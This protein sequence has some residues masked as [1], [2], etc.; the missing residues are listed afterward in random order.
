MDSQD[1]VL[2]S[3]VPMLKP[4]EFEMWKIRIKQYMLLTD[5]AL[6]EVVEHGP[7][8][9]EPAVAGAPQKSDADKKRKQTEMKALS[10]LLL[11]IPNE[12]QHQFCTCPDAKSLWNA[13]EKRFYGTKSSKRNQKALL[14]QQYENFTSTKNESMTQ[15]FDRFNKL[16]GELVNVD[17]KMEKDEVNRK[18]L[19]SLSEEWT[20]YTVSFRQGDD[21]E[22]KELEDLYNDLRIF[23][24]EVEAKRRPTGYSHTI[25]LYSSE[26]PSSNINTASTANINPANNNHDNTNDKPS[27]SQDANGDA[28][29]EAFLANHVRSPLINDDLEQINADDLE[30]MDIKWQMA[31]LTMRMKRFIRRTG[32]NN[33]DAKRGDLAGFDK[34]KVRCYK[35]NEPGHYARECKESGTHQQ[36]NNGGQAYAPRPNR[37]NNSNSSQALVSQEGMGFDWSD[38]AEEAI[39]NHA[40]MAKITEPE[41][42]AEVSSKLCSDSCV[43]TVKKYRDHNQTMSDTI[44]TME[45]DRREYRIV[46]ENLEDQIKSYKENE[47]QFEYD[48]NYWKWEKKEFEKKLVKSGE[49]LESVKKELEKAKEDLDK[50]SKSSKALEEIL[51]AQVHDELKRGIGYHNTPPPRN[52]TYI[53]PTTDILDRLNREE[54]KEGVCNID[55]SSSDDEEEQRDKT[56]NKS[57]ETVPEEN[58]ILTNEKGGMPFVPSKNTTTS[59]KGKEKIVDQEP[60]TSQPAKG[61]KHTHRNDSDPGTSKQPQTSA[62]PRGNKRNWNNQWA[63][64]HGVDLNKINKP[65]PCFICCN[66]NHLAKDCYYNPFNQRMTFQNQRVNFQNQKQFQTRRTEYNSRWS[67]PKPVVK[68]QT[69]QK[70]KNQPKKKFN[71]QKKKVEKKTV[72]IVTKW[73]PKASLSNT[74]AST[75]SGNKSVA[76]ESSGNNQKDIEVNTA[77]SNSSSG[78]SNTGATTSFSLR[79]PIVTKYSSHEIPNKDY[80]LKLNRLTEG[81]P[82][83]IENLW[84]VDSGCSRH[85]TGNRSFLEDF[86]RFNG[87]YVAFGDNPKGGKVSGKGKVT[88]V[89]ESLILLKTPRKDNVYCLDLHGMPSEVVNCLFSKASVTESPLWH[90]RMG[91]MNIKTMNLLVKNQLVRG[92]PSKEF[93]LD[94][95]CVDCLKGKQHKASHKSKT[96][97]TIS[98]PLQLLH[99]DLFGPTN[100]M[101]IGKKSY[102]LVIIDDYS[103]FTWVFF[104]RTKDETSGLI[105]PFVKRVEN[106]VNL[107]VKV[108]RSDNGTEFKNA[109]LNSFCEEKGIERQFSA[110]RTPQQNGVAERRNRTLIEAARTMLADSKLPI[111]FWAE[112]VNTACYVQNRV[113]V[114]NKADDG[115]FVGYS[116]QT[117]AV[118]VFNT[119]SR[120]IEESD[121]VKFNEHTPNVHGTGPDW[122]FD[123][124]SLTNSLN[125][126]N[127]VDTGPIIKEKETDTPFVLFPPSTISSEEKESETEAQ[128][129]ASE[130]QEGDKE[131]AETPQL[132]SNVENESVDTSEITQPDPTESD[133]DDSNLGEILSEEP[134]HL[135]ITQ[136]NHP[137]SQVI[138]DVASPMIT[139]KQSRE[140][141]YVNT[142]SGMLSCFLSQNEPKKVLDAMKDP[143][144]IEA[145]QEELL[146]FVL[147]H[148]WDLVDLPKGHRVIGTKWIFRNKTD[149]RGIVIKNKARLVAQGYTQEEG[150]DYDDVFA[151]VARIEA[152]RLFLAFASYKGFKVYQMDVKSAFLYGTIDEEVYVCQPPGF[153]DPKYP[154]RVCK[155]R[156]ALYGL[157]Q[158]PRAWYDTLSSYLLENKFERGVIDKTLFIKRTK[159]DML[160]VQIYVD[161]IIFGSTKEDMCKEFEELMHKKFK[162]SSMGE[163]TL[164]LGLQVK[165]KRDGIFINQSKYV[166][167][168]HQKFGMNDAKP[169]STPM[170]THKHLTADVEGEEVDVHQY[171]SMI[172]SL[173]YLTAS[174]PDIMFVVCV[175]ARFQVRP[176]ESHLHAVKRIFKYLKGQPRLGLWYPND[177]SFDLVAYTDKD[178]GG[179]N[180]DRKSTSGGCQFLGGRLVSWQC[181]KQT[182]VSQS[183]TEAEYIAASQCCSQVLW[184]QNQMQDYGLSFLQTPIYIDNN[185]AIS[186]VN[187]PVKH[188][189]TKHIEIKYHLIR[190]CNEKKLIQVLKVHTNDQYANLF[191]KAFDVGRVYRIESIMESMCFI[192]DHNKVGYF[193]KDVHS[194]GFEDILDFLASSHIA[195]AA[196]INPTIYIQHQ[197][198]FWL[199]AVIQEEQ[200]V[201]AIQTTIC[202]HSLTLTPEKIRLHLQFHD[203]KGIS[204]LS[205]KTLMENLLKIGYTGSKTSLKYLKGKLC[206]QW[207]FFVHTLLHC[208]SKKTTGFG[209]FS[210]TM[211]SAL[212]CLATNQ[213]FNFSQMIFDDLVYNLENI[214]NSKVKT[215]YMFSRFVQEVIT[216]ELTAVPMNGDIYKSHALGHKVFANMKR[217][218]EGSNDQF[219]PLFSTMMRVNHPQGEA[220]GLQPTQPSISSDDLPTPITDTIPQFLEK[221][222]TPT[223]KKYQRKN[224][225][226]PS[227]SGSKPNEPLSQQ[228][229]HSPSDSTQR[230]TPGVQP[231]SSIKKVPSK[232]KDGHVVGEAQTTDVAQ[233]VHQAS[234]NISK[235][236][237]TTTPSEKS[238]GGPR[239]Q[240]TKGASSASARLKT[241]VKKLKDPVMEVNTSKPGESRFSQKELMENFSTIAKDLKAFE[242]NF[243]VHDEKHGSHEARL[244]ILEKLATAQH[245]MLKLHEAQLV[246]QAKVIQAQGAS[247]ASMK[248]TIRALRRRY[249]T[250]VAFTKGERR[251]EFKGES[252]QEKEVVNEPVQHS[253]LPVD[254]I[255]EVV[256]DSV[257]KGE[258][259]KEDEKVTEET[260]VAD[261]PVVDIAEPELQKAEPEINEDDLTI[262]ELLV[263][264]PE[265]VKPTKGVVFKEPEVVKK[266]D[267]PVDPKD[268]GKEKM[269]EEAESDSDTEVDEAKRKVLEYE[270]SEALARKLSM[271]DQERVNKEIEE[272]KAAA[273]KLQE[274]KEKKPVKKTQKKSISKTETEKRRIMVRYLSGALGKPVQ[275]FSRWNMEEI[276][277]KYNVTREAMH[278]EAMEEQQVETEE[279]ALVQRKRKRDQIEEQVT[280]EGNPEH[281]VEKTKETVADSEQQ[282]VQVIEKKEEIAEKTVEKE[283]EVTEQIEAQP[284][285]AIRKKSIAK[286]PKMSKEI[287][288]PSNISMW[289]YFENNQMDYFKV[290]RSDGTNEVFA[291]YLGIFRKLSK[292]DLKKMYEIA[293][294]KEVE[295]FE[296]ARML[297]E[298]LKMMFAFSKTKAE[299]KKNRK[300]DQDDSIGE[301]KVISWNTYE[302]RVFSVNFEKG[303]MSFFLMDKRYDFQP[304]MMGSMLEVKKKAENLSELDKELIERLREQLLE[305]NANYF[306]EEV[307]ELKQKKVTGWG[308]DQN[309]KYVVQL[310]DGSELCDSEWENILEECTRENLKEMYEQRFTVIKVAV[311]DRDDPDQANKRKFSLECLF[312]LF[313]PF[314][315]LGVKNSTCED[316]KEWRWF[317]KCKVYSLSTNDGEMEYYF[318]ECET[319]ALDIQRLQCM[320]KVNLSTRGEPTRAARLLVKKMHTYLKIRLTNLAPHAEKLSL[321]GDC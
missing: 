84:H 266:N 39:Q 48:Y 105:K 10:T 38:Q 195:Y 52:H 30:E 285:K 208:F 124:D 306:D 9:P 214:H 157:H 249:N 5:Y 170:V 11:A 120:T 246:K 119:V 182:T 276:E 273:K 261:E 31:M 294:T 167:T 229:E 53:P 110:P 206:P 42:L 100:V 148:V 86:T 288:E 223:L 15:T 279:V 136:K 93:T 56:E 251:S 308:V 220:S 41:L 303:R 2:V 239:C 131:T 27:L 196:T 187:N 77:A 192:K 258:N 144:W 245:D 64:T 87:G 88:G 213:V 123:I 35:C 193:K 73:V 156:K 12:Y 78:I 284:S 79:Q 243:F 318:E 23:E 154:D 175:C 204:M 265:V 224:R 102:C 108:I 232:E 173:M 141:G 161:D 126:S 179:A 140:A 149:E 202:G 289:I 313:E 70:R 317:E 33:F 49:E 218:A 165:Q 241:K 63:Q 66:L 162:M 282:V 13:L 314:R 226:A 99:M 198:D 44:K 267:L 186:I 85:M 199:N 183:T 272:R 291:N 177:T 293:C 116:I 121:N 311:N 219:T 305:L 14:K 178:Y 146:Q 281:G 115:F 184:I 231:H 138:G 210:S 225:G 238:Q 280:T 287:E 164:F 274:R 271:E 254:E 163:L 255:P 20:M 312:W 321:G 137:A 65:K 302:N 61:G 107:R 207:R 297:V 68:K 264:M 143:S 221:T 171:R 269:I 76:S 203:E 50:F 252:V 256:M 295:D 197:H 257:V 109:D 118:R 139:R 235:T 127:A 51:K 168:M 244:D 111:T 16:V 71:V 97:N 34:S 298:D 176:K 112:A 240:E 201:K 3:K 190:D 191:T 307:I 60:A 29:L 188:S 145:M 292:G 237:T 7:S 25:A 43:E 316:V 319:D 151:P 128:E 259:E 82:D 185:S 320:M 270:A 45:I 230:D 309:L 159:T 236:P 21:L 166:A 147:Q 172:G 62:K 150:I 216:K 72:K 253:E 158:A 91:H 40:L 315:L 286:R 174:R 74:T 133:P 268:K 242:K 181:K 262:A 301:G 248:G 17:V 59:R 129:D 106:Q 6:W 122:L 132:E 24:A 263:K 275:F 103:R 234:L 1:S 54:L 96:I 94:D 18:F 28:V 215:F 135:T 260:Q 228:L 75:S 22:D 304:I 114:V 125:M 113:H 69:V 200:G 81:N 95:N 212:V 194:E 92:L 227:S 310:D 58:N 299:L 160:L 283:V 80:L 47:L 209:E 250:L 189:K 57:Q 155:L 101:S 130:H 169:A 278:L 300:R 36:A 217:P 4:N 98:A 83:R 89:D 247:I 153:E 90:R 180:L 37:G 277:N 205:T 296:E 55:P 26:N 19:R 67:V 8:V 104:L 117:K 32:R 134:L 233:G 152:I 142:H 211:A 222:P 290:F 46:I